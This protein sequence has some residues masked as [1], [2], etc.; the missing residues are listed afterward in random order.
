MKKKKIKIKIKVDLYLFYLVCYNTNSV[1]SNHIKFISNFSIVLKA[2]KD[3][4]KK[5]HFR[6]RSSYLMI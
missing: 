3:S 5:G 6:T 4:F 1:N 2:I